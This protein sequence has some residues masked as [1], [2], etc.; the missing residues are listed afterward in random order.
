MSVGE[1]INTEEYE[2]IGTIQGYQ[3][4]VK[5]AKDGLTKEEA[6]ALYE[7]GCRSVL[8]RSLCEALEGEQP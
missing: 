2:Y 4:Y 8:Y 7:D 3:V 5:Y 6:Q 1:W